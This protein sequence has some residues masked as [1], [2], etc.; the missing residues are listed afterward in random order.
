MIVLV[1]AAL[2]SCV[3]PPMVPA[4]LVAPQPPYGQ[5][6]PPPT[7]PPPPPVAAGPAKVAMLVPLSG[8]NAGLGQAI[9][10]AAQL[11]LF[12]TGGDQLTLV[13]RDT[14]GTPG[15]AADAARA[16]VGDGVGLILGPLLAGEV[17]AVK[18]IAR[19]AHVNVIAFS[20]VTD[21]AGGNT[22]LMG[23]LPRQEVVREVAYA[24][25]RGI[26][27][28]AA[29]APDTAYGHLMVDALRES[30]PSTGGTVAKSSFTARAAATPRP[31][32]RLLPGG[33][34]PPS[35]DSAGP[36]RAGLH[37]PASGP[38]ST[39]PGS[40]GRAR[41]RQHRI[42]PRRRRRLRRI[43]MRCCCRRAATG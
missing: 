24:R 7:P 14:R 25:Q 43:S 15:G 28:F 11:A 1:V 27:R 16:A 31:R 21:L 12:E 42:S 23:F 34:A 17:E 37:G 6:L 5:P 35:R 20:T 10:D 18:P 30:A 2:A 22:F 38:G 40:T 36:D 32:S 26:A 41:S 8:P 9:L 4:P 33:A 29:L 3:P 19:D 39:G 13:P